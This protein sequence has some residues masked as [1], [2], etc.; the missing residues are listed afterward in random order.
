MTEKNAH[1]EYD[2]LK[3]NLN[4]MFL[5]DDVAELHVM[6]EFA[7]KRIEELFDYH[8]VRLNNKC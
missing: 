3:G 1:I 8:Y 7:K 6:H 4:R 5:T 2:M